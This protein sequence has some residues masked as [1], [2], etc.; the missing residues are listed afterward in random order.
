MS[1]QPDDHA[2][3]GHRKASVLKLDAAIEEAKGVLALSSWSARADSGPRTS[4]RGQMRTREDHLRDAILAAAMHIESNED[5]RPL[6]TNTKGKRLLA[7]L[8]KHIHTPTTESENADHGSMRFGI[9][10]V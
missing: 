8:L 5:L 2:G 10:D 6:T 4:K 7:R 9:H 1:D 3:L